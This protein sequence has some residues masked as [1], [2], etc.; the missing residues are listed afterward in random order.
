MMQTGNMHAESVRF[1]S[2][3][4]PPTDTTNKTIQSTLKGSDLIPQ[5]T[6]IVSNAVFLEGTR[7]TLLEKFAFDDVLSDQQCPSSI[8]E[9]LIL[10]TRMPHIHPASENSGTDFLLS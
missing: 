2:R 4:H 10:P 3:G 6:F 8:R 7:L 1:N 5:I 9:Y